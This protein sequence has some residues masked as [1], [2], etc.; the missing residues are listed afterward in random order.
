MTSRE[1]M[2]AAMRR[3]PVDRVPVPQSFWDA[4]PEEQGFRWD[5]LEERI[6]WHKRLG[7][8]YYLRLPSVGYQNPEIKQRHWKENDPKE[9]YPILCS[10][11]TSPKGTLTAKLRLSEDYPYEVINLFD[12]YNTARFTKPLLN[13][14]DDLAA[15]VK[16]DFWKIKTGKELEAWRE[17]CRYLRRLA[18]KEGLA[19]ERTSGA[20]MTLLIRGST[21]EQAIML[22]LEYPE[23]TMAFLGHMNRHA[24]ET[25]PYFFEAE[26]DVVRRYGWYESADFWSPAIFAKF[27]APFI[28]RI[29]K[30]V[31]QAGLPC[32]YEMCTGVAPM[33]PELAKLNFDCL[34]ALEPVC[35][36]QDIG[37]I[38]KVLGDKKSFW[39]GLS[40]PLHIGRGTPA[41]V[42]KA[43]RKAFETFGYRGFLLSAVPS[44]RKHWPW[45]NVEAMMDEYRKIMAE[46]QK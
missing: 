40:A 42:R 5:S 17:Q 13:N 39:T 36:G 1:R 18:D 19:L 14:G 10:E 45:E 41:D 8:D 38:V 3:Q 22:A 11:W 29:I 23:E 30:L 6:Q 24:E 7:F 15:F 9:K 26:V 43:V 20:G 44:I 35:T 33:L 46:I 34:G 21:V 31:H 4:E 32:Y 2:L 12:D 25:L 27:A 37:K 16:M 28:Q